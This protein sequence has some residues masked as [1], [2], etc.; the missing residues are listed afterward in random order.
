[1]YLKIKDLNKKVL[2]LLGSKDVISDLTKENQIQAVYRIIENDSISD[3][4]VAARVLSLG[5]III[6]KDLAGIL[7]KLE[8]SCEFVLKERVKKFLWAFNVYNSQFQ[9]NILV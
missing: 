8:N 7:L 6:L 3:A 4:K 5:V 9:K 1:M 2:E